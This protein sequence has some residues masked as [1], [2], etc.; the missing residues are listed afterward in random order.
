MVVNADRGV[1]SRAMSSSS[2]LVADQDR[3]SPR[4]LVT[5]ETRQS[6]SHGSQP[7]LQCSPRT[8]GHTSVAEGVTAG[9]VDHS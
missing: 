4:E 3:E 8:G 6:L 7:F 5:A 1:S 2:G 9:V